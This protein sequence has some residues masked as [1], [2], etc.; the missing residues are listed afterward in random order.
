MPVGIDDRMVEAGFDLG[1]GQMGA[2]GAPPLL[3]GA[4]PRRC[5]SNRDGSAGLNPTQAG[6]MRLNRF[7]F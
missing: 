2:H 1:R 6:G 3:A 7:L 5:R 4:Q